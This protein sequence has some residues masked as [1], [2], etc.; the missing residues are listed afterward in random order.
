MTENT[1]NKQRDDTSSLSREERA[2]KR[3]QFEKNREK[4]RAESIK[5]RVEKIKKAKRTLKEETRADLIE[6][7]KQILIEEGLAGRIEETRKALDEMRQELRDLR[8]EHRTEI[9]KIREDLGVRY[10]VSDKERARRRERFRDRQEHRRNTLELIKKFGKEGLTSGQLE[11]FDLKPHRKATK[12]LP[13]SYREVATL[14]NKEEHYTLQGKEWTGASVKQY[15]EKHGNDNYGR[16]GHTKS[17]LAIA[18]AK[19]EKL[20]KD[21]AIY[22]RDEVL[23]SID[24][25]QPYLTIAKELNKRGCKTRTGGKWGNVAVKRLLERI[26]DL[27]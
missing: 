7:A 9:K 4:R 15:I 16:I 25:N 23:P 8:T 2:E 6:R 17:K 27:S 26:D 10:Q 19:R 20:V 22:M 5:R 11:L 24:T 3:A 13:K 1:K 21:H 12:D 14:L 18:N